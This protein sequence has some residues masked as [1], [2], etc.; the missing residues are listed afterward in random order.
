MKKN[1]PRSGARAGREKREARASAEIGGLRSAIGWSIAALPMANGGGNGGMAARR[2]WFPHRGRGRLE[3]GNL[4]GHIRAYPGIENM[5]EAPKRH[6]P[7]RC[8]NWQARTPA[9]RGMGSGDIP[10]WAGVATRCGWSGRTQPRSGGVP[11]VTVSTGPV[12]ACEHG[13]DWGV[14]PTRSGPCAAADPTDTAALRR[15]IRVSPTKSDQKK[16]WK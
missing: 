1:S 3:T 2:R 9:P 10:S 15:F 5:K 4:S 12:A 7:G 8:V 11:G 13:W 6:A 16:P 14:P